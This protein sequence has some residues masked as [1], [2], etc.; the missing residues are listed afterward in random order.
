MINFIFW[1]LY[2]LK[3]IFNIILSNFNYFIKIKKTNYIDININTKFNMINENLYIVRLY[4]S[5]YDMGKMYGKFM[6]E[7]LTSDGNKCYNYI[8]ENQYIFNKKIPLEIRKDNIIDSIMNLYDNNKKYY[9]DDIINFIKGIS[10]ETN[11]KF[12][13]L[14]VVNL[15]NDMMDNHCIIL[16][17]KINNK[18]LNLRTFD[19]GSPNLSQALII[20]HPKNKYNYCSLNASFHFGIVS[21]LSE[22]NIFFGETYH[23]NNLGNINYIGTPFHHMA[24]HVLNSCVNIQESIDI[25]KNITRTSNLELLLSDNDDGKILLFSKDKLIE[26]NKF[27]NVT[28]MEMNNFLK[29]KKYLNNIDNVLSKFIQNTKSGELHCFITYDGYLYISVTTKYLQSYNNTF[30]RLKISELYN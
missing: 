7:I 30:Y 25:M 21:G 3:C 8:I 2:Y 23:D 6:K 28:P 18:I 4:G 27:Y 10:N 13:K 26:K 11:I 22:K 1:L 17:K 12:E 19:Y 24:H 20:F 5:Y 14:I 29:N 16:N 15:F 9:N